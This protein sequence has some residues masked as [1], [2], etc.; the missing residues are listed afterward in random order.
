SVI[1]LWLAILYITFT[2]HSPVIAEFGIRE[3]SVAGALI[4]FNFNL[5]RLSIRER[6]KGWPGILRNSRAWLV[7]TLGIVVLCQTKWFLKSAQMPHL[8]GGAPSP[9]YGEAV[10]LYVI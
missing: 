7:I 6:Q 4:L 5:L 2:T 3:A 1:G 10:Y 8:T 9:V